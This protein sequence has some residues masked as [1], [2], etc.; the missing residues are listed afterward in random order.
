MDAPTGPWVDTFKTLAAEAPSNFSSLRGAAHNNGNMF[1]TSHWFDAT[2]PLR[3][4]AD[5]QV[6]D[7]GMM[8]SWYYQC[9]IA[10][11]ADPTTVA[12]FFDK[13]ARLCALS[14]SRFSEKND[15]H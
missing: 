1:N 9:T 12:A 13:A 2:A 15:I 5:C 11:N 6:N 4:A 14:C 7:G 3:G 10:R 8:G